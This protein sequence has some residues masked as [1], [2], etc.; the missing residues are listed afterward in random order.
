M[1]QHEDD[2]L[3]IKIAVLE[4][5]AGL[6]RTQLRSMI[7]L[8]RDAG[9]AVSCTNH[10]SVGWLWPAACEVSMA[11]STVERASWNGAAE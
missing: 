6:A 4:P 11:R 8:A 3:G 1:A 9:H 2:L 10:G 7:T 5:T